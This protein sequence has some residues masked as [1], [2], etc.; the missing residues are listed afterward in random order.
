MIRILAV[1]Y[2]GELDLQAIPRMEFRNIH[3]ICDPVCTH[4][5]IFMTLV[6]LPYEY[7]LSFVVQ[8]WY[9]QLMAKW[10]M[11]CLSMR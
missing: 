3:H 2:S 10:Y 9:A 1:F 11:Q 6:F 4:L 7:G 8:E 5:N